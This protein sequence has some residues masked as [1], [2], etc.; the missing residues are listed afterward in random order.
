MET[1]IRETTDRKRLPANHGHVKRSEIA[2]L[3]DIVDVLA[4]SNPA[5]IR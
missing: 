5:E 1:K 4:A 3:P 2:V